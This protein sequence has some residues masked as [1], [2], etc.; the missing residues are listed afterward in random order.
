MDQGLRTKDGKTI[1]MGIIN[2]VIKTLSVLESSKRG[3]SQSS[4]LPELKII[5]EEVFARAQETVRERVVPQ[6]EVPLTT[7]GQ[8]LLVGNVYCGHCGRTA[9]TGYRRTEL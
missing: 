8:S 4:V 6:S 7:R 2:R 5:D 1:T 3:E 9:L